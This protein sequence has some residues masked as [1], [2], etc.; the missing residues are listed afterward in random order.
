MRGISAGDNVAKSRSVSMP[1]ASI[2]AG[3]A[4]V[5]VAPISAN[6]AATATSSLAIKG[7]SATT[8]SMAAGDGCAA[9]PPCASPPAGA[10]PCVTSLATLVPPLRGAAVVTGVPRHSCRTDAPR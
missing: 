5:R 9:V 4:T 3:I 6:R 8:E 10:P 1:P 2:S 7:V